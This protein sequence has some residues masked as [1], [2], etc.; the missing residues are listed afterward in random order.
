MNTKKI[1]LGTLL[2]GS[3]FFFLGWLLF[4]IVL[5]P[6]MQGN[7]NASI[8]RPMDQMLFGPLILSNLIW[9]LLLTLILIW[10]QSTGFASGLLTGALM[11]FL[12]SLATD[13]SFYSM[14]TF[15]SGPMGIA[16]DVSGNTILFSL[17]GA[18]ISLLF[19]DKTE[20]A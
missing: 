2:G 20:R 19:K 9:G 1:L 6:L 18:L 15:F 13:L 16:L 4:G 5:A 11:G 7:S 3:G 8:N 10:R 14:T 12:V 17:V